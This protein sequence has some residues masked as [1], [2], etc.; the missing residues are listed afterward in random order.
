MP[1]F[2]TFHPMQEPLKSKLHRAKQL[3]HQYNKLSPDDK[4]QKR[5]ILTK[6]LPNVKFAHIEPNFYCDFG[7]NIYAG[8]GLYLNHNVTILD[9]AKIN[10]G[11]RVLVG[12][13]TVITATTHPKNKD[14]RLT[15]E[16][17]AAP[18]N[19]GNDVWI[20]ASAI[21]LPGVTIGDEAIIAAGAV[22]I[23]D[24][25]AKTTFIK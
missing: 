2:T 21:I 17:M 20:G 14:Q 11:D 6:L 16:E 3:C 12:P 7:D 13:N 23:K 24:V 25:P 22:V 19:I 4:K 5:Q 8:T 1:D 15:G 9:G 18:I 10:F